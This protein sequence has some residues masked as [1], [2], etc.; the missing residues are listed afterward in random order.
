MLCFPNCKINLGLFVTGKRPDG[1]HNLETVFYPV[2]LKDALEIVPASEQTSLQLSGKTVAGDG[3]DNLV[4]KAW[5][6]LKDHF[7]KQIPELDIFLHKVIPMGAGLGG[8]SSNGSFMLR[9]INNYC[10]LGLT[11]DK[12]L[13]LALLLGSDCPF[14]IK[15][16]PQWA[17]GRGQVLEPLSIS[18]SDYSLQL[19]CPGLHVST[20]KA[21]E[22]LHPGPAP[23]DL[24]KLPGLPPE[25]WKKHIRNDFE[26]PVFSNYPEL[27][28]MK[29]QLYSQG[30]VYASMSGSGS[31]IFGIF[32]KGERAN[33][34][35]D[36]EFEEFSLDL[37]F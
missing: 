36:L 30:A 18:L 25:E 33:I 11:S 34:K 28:E 17:G 37:K 16:T 7:P 4:M 12:L 2:P 6:L 10:H 26:V 27:R 5:Q 35:S 21:F 1:Y 13:E 23:F 22:M 19:I 29:D 8:G 31:S 3:Q 9:L 15:N 20:A 32:Q 14:F 24:K